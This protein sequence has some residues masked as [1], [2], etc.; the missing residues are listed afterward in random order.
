[1]AIKGVYVNFSFRAYSP[2]PVSPPNLKRWCEYHAEV[3]DMVLLRGNWY[4]EV[5]C[6]R[7]E[8]ELTADGFTR[9]D[10]DRERVNQEVVFRV[11]KAR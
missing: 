10:G 6:L 8:Y 5:E 3:L 2:S 11:G 7:I 9:F 4:D 1:M